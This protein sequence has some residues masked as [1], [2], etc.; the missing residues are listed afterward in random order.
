[1]HFLKAQDTVCPQSVQFHLCLLQKVWHWHVLGHMTLKD[2]VWF[3]EEHLSRNSFR[4]PLKLFVEV[5]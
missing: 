5:N 1:M 3:S 2:V 4:S